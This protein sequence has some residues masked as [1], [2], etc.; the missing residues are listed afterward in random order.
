MRRELPAFYA[1]MV[2]YGRTFEA[3]TSP[4]G[5]LFWQRTLNT[6]G[7]QLQY[8]SFCTLGKVY[9]LTPTGS[10]ANERTQFALQHV[11]GQLRQRMAHMDAVTHIY[12]T[13][14][15]HDEFPY[16]AA[17]SKWYASERCSE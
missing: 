6:S 7:K 2:A 8:P 4:T 5:R 13:N 14:V 12:C 15:T 11:Q 3:G 9:M 16:E 17:L 10:V 1:H